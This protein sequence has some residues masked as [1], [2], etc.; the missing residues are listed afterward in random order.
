VIAR[1]R[2]L[3]IAVAL[4]VLGV[5]SAWAGFQPVSLADDGG[6]ELHVAGLVL[7]QWLPLGGLGV[8]LAGLCLVLYLSTRRRA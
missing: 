5:V 3:A 1:Q 6:S 2:E 4:L 8:S 7:P